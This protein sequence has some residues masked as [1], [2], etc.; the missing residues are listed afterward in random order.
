MTNAEAKPRLTYAKIAL[1]LVLLYAVWAVREL[2]WRTP[3]AGLLGGWGEPIFGSL[4]KLLI[5]TLPAA[6]LARRYREDMQIP[7]WF[8]HRVQWARLLLWMALTILYSVIAAWIVNG[9]VYIRADFQPQMLIGTVLFVGITEEAVFRGFL[10]N[11]LLKRM[12]QNRAL[13]ITAFL[14]T[15]IHF[16]IWYTR[17]FFADP[18]EL[19][20]S[21]LSVFVL[22]VLFGLAFIKDEN[23]I[24]PILVHMAWNTGALLLFG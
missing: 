24:S 22:G 8:R 16:P 20:R 3:L 2:S 9:A 21:C 23:L 11:A 1:Y 4:E 7:Y 17:G 6:L 18:I 19:L 12:P 5:W 13:A 10:L 15:L 14:F